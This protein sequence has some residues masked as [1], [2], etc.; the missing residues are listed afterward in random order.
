MLRWVNFGRRFRLKV[1]HF[2]TPVHNHTCKQLLC[3]VMDYIV[4]DFDDWIGRIDAMMHRPEEAQVP[5]KI[6]DALNILRHE[7]I[8][9]W[10]EHHWFWAEEPDYDP[11]AMA[12]SSGK[13]DRAKQDVLYVRLSA[14]GSVASAPSGVA[15]ETVQNER[16]R[17]RRFAGL[18]KDVLDGHPNPGLDYQRIEESIRLLFAFKSRTRKSA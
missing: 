1:G 11:D 13:Q 2:C 9:R 17:A 10:V 3:V 15:L 4:P 18:A 12:I 16:E 7:K 6:A 14:D 8:G 5:R